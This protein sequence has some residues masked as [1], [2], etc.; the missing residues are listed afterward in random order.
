MNNVCFHYHPA[1]QGSFLW[2]SSTL[3]FQ[4]YVKHNVKMRHFMPLCVFLA[5]KAKAVNGFY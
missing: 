4:I 1:R 2:V 5:S 3:Q